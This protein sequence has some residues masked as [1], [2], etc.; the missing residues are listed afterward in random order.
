MNKKEISEIKKQ[1]SPNNQNL[2]LLCGWR[3][4]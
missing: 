4:K 3:E 1:Y 2:R